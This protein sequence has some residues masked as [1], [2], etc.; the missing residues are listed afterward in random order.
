MSL[1]PRFS[2]MVAAFR[3]RQRRRALPGRG[4]GAK[5]AIKDRPKYRAWMQLNENDVRMK[6]Q[7]Q[8][9]ISF[10]YLWNDWFGEFLLL[11][12]SCGICFVVSCGFCVVELPI[13]MMN[14]VPC[15]TDC[16][17]DS[18]IIQPRSSPWI[19]LLLD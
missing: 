3:C 14:V 16:Q 13:M 17:H 6:C 2:T 18:W 19:T 1:D 15:F 12:V 8:M 10:T 5:G 11:I 7:Y 9:N 4:V